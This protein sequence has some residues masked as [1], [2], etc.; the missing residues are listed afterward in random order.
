MQLNFRFLQGNFNISLLVLALWQLHDLAQ[1]AA[2]QRR[3]GI[4]AQLVTRASSLAGP[5][6]EL[7]ARA[8]VSTGMKNR[9]SLSVFIALPFR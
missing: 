8:L 6:T 3:F 5:R 4:L 9:A 7:V 2:A 1:T